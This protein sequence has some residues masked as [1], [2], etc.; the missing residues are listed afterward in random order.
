MVQFIAEISSNHAR[1]PGRCAALIAA[2]AAAGCD[3]VKF[4]LFRVDALFAPEILARS[5]EHRRRKD[6]ELPV[7][8][9]PQLA[10]QA[11]DR[12]MAFGCT[13]FDLDAVEALRAHVDFL[14]VA[15][16]ELI[17]R[18]LIAACARTGLP[19]ILST[20]MATLEE[21]VAAVAG[22]RED[23]A[24]D[25][26][27]L[28]CV[29]S[30]PTP[31]AQCNLAAMATIARA[32]GVPVGWS[33]HSRS[34]EVVLRAV[35]RWN[36]AMVEFHLDLDGSGAEYAPGH[37]W[38]PEEIAPVIA[39]CRQGAVLDGD[40]KKAPQ[41]CELADRDWRADPVDGLRP[42]LATRARWL[43]EAS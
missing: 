1:D 42:L 43:E 4:Q 10:A 32:C 24:G 2:A 22:A 23:G 7:E 9:I 34:P 5:A 21:A 38:L 15:S 37:C 11:R 8:L 28:H 25:L 18:D 31:P 16:Y 40:G 35:H 3:A 36:A 27:V 20:G 29:S 17:W 39:A 33:D 19:T 30:Y 26:T 6:W 41:P 14:K 13:P 12:G